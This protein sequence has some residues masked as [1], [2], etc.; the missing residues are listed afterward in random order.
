MDHSETGFIPT[1][2]ARAN[3]G[4]LILLSAQIT[5]VGDTGTVHG[6]V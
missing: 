1:H 5:T 6:G 3:R 2:E 4:Q